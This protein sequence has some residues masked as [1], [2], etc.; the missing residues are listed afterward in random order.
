M[1]NLPTPTLGLAVPSIGGDVNSWGAELNGDLVTL[2]ALGDYP[3]F[4]VVTSASI[5]FSNVPETIIEAYGGAAGIVI[6]L[7]IG[8]PAGIN[9]AFTIKKMDATNGV[10]AVNALVSTIEGSASYDLFNQWQ[11]A[12]FLWD[13]TLWIVVGNN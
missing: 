10:V 6:N 1:P 9:R 12:K 13:G 2:D 7:P 5:V 4:P 3:V 8:I 11:Y